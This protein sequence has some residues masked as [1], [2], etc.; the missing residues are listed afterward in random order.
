M[1]AIFALAAA[2]DLTDGYL[3]LRM[4]AEASDAL[5]RIPKNWR[6]HPDVL[7]RRLIVY[8]G[9]EQWA[10]GRRLAKSATVDYP[11]RAD[12]WYRLAIIEAGDGDNDAAMEAVRRCI[13]ADLDGKFDLVSDD[14]LKN[15]W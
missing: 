1:R 5:R 13:A 11:M 7:D 6:R 15:I 8:T 10:E 3:T 9:M 14:A 12:L 4:W 2:L